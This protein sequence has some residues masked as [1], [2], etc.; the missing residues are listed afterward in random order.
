MTYLEIQSQPSHISRPEV[1]LLSAIALLL[2]GVLFWL[3]VAQPPV[4]EVKIP[5]MS[6]A[7]SESAVMVELSAAAPEPA[8]P[9]PPPEPT[10]SEEPLPEPPKP[11][12]DE[13][14]LTP[15]PKP[16]EV[17]KTPPAPPKKPAPQPVK[18]KPQT[19][20]RVARSASQT[21]SASPAAAT[22]KPSGNAPSAGQGQSIT[23]A[24]SG[25]QSLGNP[26]PDYPPLALRRQQQGSVVLRILVLENGRAGQV[27]VTRSSRSEWLDQAAVKAVQQW[28]FIPAK[29]GS[30]AI[31]G[32]A[33]QTI[34]F[35]LPR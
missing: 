9:T 14:A 13:D 7:G 19:T 8:Q 24:V 23:P 26:P 22:G 6:T 34:T 2:H 30:V 28:R 1:A 21:P 25:M 29:R 3:L 18:P 10:S 15:A 31:K 33:I 20:A 35:T 32:Y 5:T 11:Q 27:T 16:P 12:R 17:V 4:T